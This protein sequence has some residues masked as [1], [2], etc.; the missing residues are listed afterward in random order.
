MALPRP[1]LTAT[2]RR[3]G[4][5]LDAW[6]TLLEAQGG[7]CAI[8]QKA[9]KTGRFNIDHFHAPRWKRLPPAERRK[10]VR[11]LLCWFCNRYYAGRSI[12]V[13]KSKSV[14]AYLERHAAKVKP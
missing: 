1:P 7:V 6:R 10:H 8:C 3:Y 12:T 9:P 5:S 13:E 2:L 14:T 11:G 4:L